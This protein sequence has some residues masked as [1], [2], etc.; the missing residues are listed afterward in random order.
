[1]RSSEYCIFE[2]F[3][4]KL[5]IQGCPSENMQL[6]NETTVQAIDCLQGSG[7]RRP[8]WLIRKLGTLITKLRR[9]LD[10]AEE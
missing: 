3:V 4:T 1:M 9:I 10:R 2:T 8:F 6:Y 7:A 5:N